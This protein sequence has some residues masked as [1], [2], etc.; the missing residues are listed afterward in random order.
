[1]AWLRAAVADDFQ[2]GDARPAWRDSRCVSSS[3]AV[4]TALAARHASSV[5]WVVRAADVHR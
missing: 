4:A 3:S 1:V 5:V 2:A